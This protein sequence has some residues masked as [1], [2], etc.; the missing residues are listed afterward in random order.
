[1]QLR[2]SA[3]TLNKSPGRAV[4]GM[5][6][7]PR[8]GELKGK[9]LLGAPG[10]GSGRAGWVLPALESNEGGVETDSLCPSVPSPTDSTQL[11]ASPKGR[12]RNSTFNPFH[13]L[14]AF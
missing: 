8:K 12:V 7:P 4:A 11:P 1:M 9:K 2:L 5:D 10:W 6:L 13:L 14:P 3:N